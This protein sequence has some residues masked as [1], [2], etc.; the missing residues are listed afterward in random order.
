MTLDISWVN[1]YERTSES[2]PRTTSTEEQVKRYLRDSSIPI[3]KLQA[4]LSKITKES[5]DS[6]V[7]WDV[8]Q[9]RTK[10][11]A[12]RILYETLKYIEV[13]WNQMIAFETSLLY[14]YN[15]KMESNQY[16]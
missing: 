10:D 3:E 16:D 2:E 7:I 11:D 9:A 12:L 5:K 14:K 13:L 6:Q 15:N 1:E 4:Q 8:M